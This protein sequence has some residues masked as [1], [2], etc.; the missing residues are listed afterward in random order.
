MTQSSS[1]SSVCFWKCDR[2]SRCEFLYLGFKPK[3]L[4]RF[5]CIVI[6]THLP[7]EL[8]MQSKEWQPVTAIH[9][10]VDTLILRE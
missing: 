2:N 9:D 8:P 7:W 1:S 5:D 3:L 6:D 4:S 10:K